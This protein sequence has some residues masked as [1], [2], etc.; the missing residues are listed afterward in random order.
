MGKREVI[1]VG[2]WWD[3]VKTECAGHLVGDQL[4]RVAPPSPV[5]SILSRFEQGISLLASFVYEHDFE[6]G[7]PIFAF[8][9]GLH[10]QGSSIFKR[11]EEFF[12]RPISMMVALREQGVDPV[13]PNALSLRSHLGAEN[14]SWGREG[15]SHDH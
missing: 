1:A 4:H 2:H 13:T 9:E 12:V 11:M 5:I 3:E 15:R 6:N 7:G 8:G 10:R 14:G